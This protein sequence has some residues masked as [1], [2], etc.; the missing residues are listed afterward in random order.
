[1]P[2]NLVF[3][4]DGECPLCSYGAHAFRIREAV[5]GIELINARDNMNHPLVQQLTALNMD[6]DEGMVIHYRGRFYHGQDALHLMAMLGSDNS[7]FNI[8]NAAL[9]KS[10]KMAKFFYPAMRATRNFLIAIKGV[11][12]INNLTKKDAPI[13]QSVFGQNWGALPPVMKKHYANRPHTNDKVTTEG[14]MKIESSFLGRLLTPLFMLAGT[15]VPHEGNDIPVTVNFLSSPTS[16]RFSFDRTFFFPGKKPYRFFSRMQPLKN[17]ELVEFMRFGFGWHA[18]YSWNGTKVILDHKGY[19]LNFFGMLLPIP[20]DLVMG[21]GY[22]EETPIDDDHFS[23]MM[24]I[25]HPLWGKIYGYS[26]TFK[27]TGVP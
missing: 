16:N 2:E 25:R 3:I 1:M 20:L 7:L 19:V 24:E 15:L 8:I 21:K 11:H 23:M 18:A 26:G 27:I 5:G 4:Y 12:K 10:E 22:A 17:N 6:L 14:V 9:F 13:F